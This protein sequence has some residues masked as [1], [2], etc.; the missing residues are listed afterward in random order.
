MAFLRLRV[1]ISFA[2][3]ACDVDDDNDGVPDTTDNCPFVSNANQLNTD[4]DSQ[5]AHSWLLVALI[6]DSACQAMHATATTTT[7]VWPTQRTTARLLTNADQT[8]TDGDGQGTVVIPPHVP[9]LICS[10]GDA[11]DSDDDND[12]VA[13]SADNCPLVSNAQQ[14]NTDGDSQGA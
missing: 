3:D 10:T 13:D 1:F 6:T 11:C 7:T 8:D 4:G 5:G 12:G 14:L 2:G 9:H